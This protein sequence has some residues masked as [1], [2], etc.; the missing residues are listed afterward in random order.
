MYNPAS[1]T[2]YPF[3]NISPG[4]WLL[5]LWSGYEDCIILVGFTCE[6]DGTYPLMYMVGT[7]M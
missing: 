6:Y 4:A 3:Y 1:T 2:L 5:G 7:S